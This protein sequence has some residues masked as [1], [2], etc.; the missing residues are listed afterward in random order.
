MNKSDVNPLNI[1]LA[2]SKG[3]IYL[4]SLTLD[5]VSDDIEN[6]FSENIE[7]VDKFSDNNYE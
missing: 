2:T 4:Y 1:A 3:F 7:W 5:I 6:M